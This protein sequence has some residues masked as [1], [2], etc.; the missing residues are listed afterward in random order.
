[1]RVALTL[2][3]ALFTF[4]A[5]ASSGSTQAV[6]IEKITPK[7]LSGSEIGFR[8]EGLKGGIPVGTVVVRVNGQ[9]VDAEFSGRAKLITK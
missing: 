8:V 1:M 6:Q 9:W 2:L 5:G 7:V 3:L 4:G